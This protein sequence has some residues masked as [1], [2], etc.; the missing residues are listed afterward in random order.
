MEMLPNLYI[1]THTH[2]SQQM[3][4]IMAITNLFA[5]TNSL[6]IYQ[7]MPQNHYSIGLHPW[8]IAEKS[9]ND[10]HLHIVKKLAKEYKNILAI[11]ETGLDKVIK[12]DFE[13]QKEIFYQHIKISE[14]CE[15]PLIIHCVRSYYEI[16]AIKKQIKPQQIWI[17][18]GFQANEQIAMACIKEECYLSLGYALL[19]E[20]PKLMKAVSAIPLEKILLET[21]TQP[22]I[23]KVYAQFAKI[24]NMTVSDLQKIMMSN[25]GKV[26]KNIHF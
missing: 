16:L 8:H 4:E 15:K 5:A 6:E 21:D 3:V 13:L 17:F 25:F 20:E 26:F 10:L 7:N 9:N 23:A 22:D 1:N 12:V 24:R 19:K 11:G 14:E 18:H 2:Q